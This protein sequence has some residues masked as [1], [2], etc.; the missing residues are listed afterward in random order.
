MK[1]SMVPTAPIYRRGPLV[2]SY[3]SSMAHNSGE[4]TNLGEKFVSKFEES[5]PDDDEGGV[6]GLKYTPH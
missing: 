1:A 4:V 6:G 2:T 3:I 5:P